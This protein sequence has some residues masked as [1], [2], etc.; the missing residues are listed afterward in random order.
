MTIMLHHSCHG[1]NQVCVAP[2]AKM[3]VI[4]ENC[5]A[6]VEFATNLC[7]GIRL[8]YNPILKPKKK[9]I[10]REIWMLR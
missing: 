1:S 7:K 5:T 2:T 6:F 3:M 4:V 10:T 8:I 9:R